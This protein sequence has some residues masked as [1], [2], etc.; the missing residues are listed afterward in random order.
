MLVDLMPKISCLLVT[1]GRYERVQQ[2]LRCF[3]NQTYPNKE[4]ILVSQGEGEVNQALFELTRTIPEVQ[5]FC[6]HSRLSLGSMRN[7]SCE[8]ANGPILCQW[9]D[10]DFYFP[11]RLTDQFKALTGNSKNVASAFTKFFKYFA[12]THE[13]YWCDWAGEGVP[14]SQYLCGSVMFYKKTFHRYNSLLYP[15]VGRQADREEDLNVLFKLLEAGRVEAVGPGHQY[16]YVYHGDN[17]YDLHHHQL[18]LLTNSG[19][20]VA[21]CDE[22]LL[23]QTLIEGCLRDYGLPGPI[24]VRS[25][26]EVAFTYDPK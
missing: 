26:H 25:L 3:Q 24:H 14:S 23:N 17:T 22:L 7:L 8:I 1:A 10:D 11:T 18:T 9:D 20:T 12:D 13:L 19:K 5:F 21:D 6:A 4:L 2:S 16:V 15:E